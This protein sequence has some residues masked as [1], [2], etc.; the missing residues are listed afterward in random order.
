MGALRTHPFRGQVLRV[1]CPGEWPPLD[2]GELRVARG[3]AVWEGGEGVQRP[4]PAVWQKASPWK[5][6]EGRDSGSD[7]GPSAAFGATGG[8]RRPGRRRAPPS[9]ARGRGPR[10]GEGRALLGAPP[11][12]EECSDSHDFS[13]LCEVGGKDAKNGAKRGVKRSG[14]K[15]VKKV[16]ERRDGAAGREAR[17]H[18]AA[19]T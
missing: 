14:F 19:R 13:F 17:R 5:L 3:P 9:A 16:R 18:R 11:V 7:N 6:A 4:P 8:G 10:Q 2:T 15:G 12:A 1:T